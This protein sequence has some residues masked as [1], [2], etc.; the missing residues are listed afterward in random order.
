[1]GWRSKL[2]V[3]RGA[4]PWYSPLS[5]SLRGPAPVSGPCSFR[6]REP[7][8]PWRHLLTLFCCRCPVHF[9][10]YWLPGS[11]SCS[12]PTTPLACRARR[13]GRIA[14]NECV[15]NV[16]LRVVS[17]ARLAYLVPLPPPQTG[18]WGRGRGGRPWVRMP[19]TQHPLEGVAPGAADSPLTPAILHF[20]TC[21]RLGATSSRR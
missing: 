16:S 6:A 4:V 7:A 15:D 20:L 3:P 11:L 17:L 2:R 1:M 12:S 8:L 14:L 10:E 18:V 19:F 21:V 13:E 9:G 5:P